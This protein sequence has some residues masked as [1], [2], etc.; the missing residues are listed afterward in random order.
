[1]SV[2]PVGSNQVQSLGT[3][4]LQQLT[5][6]T[7]STQDSSGLSSLMGDQ[8]TLSPAAQQLTKAPDA[9]T[10]AMKDL[11]SGK[12]TVQDDVSIVKNYFA[13]HPEGLSSLMN[14]LQGSTGTYAVAS[15]TG[16]ADTLLTALMNQQSNASDPSGLLNLLG[17]QGQDSLFATLGD[18]GSGSGSNSLSIFG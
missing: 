2:P 16:S 7:T 8:L 18:S 3:A 14:S 13:Q 1:M 12:K 5:G 9:V 6:Q 17:G 4:L 15:A 10:Q 11:I